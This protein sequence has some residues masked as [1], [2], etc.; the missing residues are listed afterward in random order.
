MLYPKAHDYVISVLDDMAKNTVNNGGDLDFFTARVRHYLDG[1]EES[2]HG[3]ESNLMPNTHEEKHIAYLKLFAFAIDLYSKR[4]VAKDL[5]DH[6]GKG[7][8]HE[9]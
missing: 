1:V 9:P 3:L 6:F 8:T 2:C 7:V 5:I 4:K